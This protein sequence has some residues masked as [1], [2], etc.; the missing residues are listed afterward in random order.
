MQLPRQGILQRYTKIFFSFALSGI[1][2]IFA[3]AGGGLSMRQSGALQFFCM[4]ALGIVIEDG[5]QHIYKQVTK[6]KTGDTLI[7]CE[8]I[9]GYTWVISFLIY[10]SPV[11]VFPATLQMREE[12]AMLSLTALKPL[13][14]GLV[15]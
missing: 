13:I 1:M 11:W 14:R 4:Q 6:R 5:A 15:R 2:H 3:D 12:E 9:I 10:T 8:R 7:T